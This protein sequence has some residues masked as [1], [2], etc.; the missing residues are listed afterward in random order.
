MK[1][2]F[3]PQ[4]V[5]I[6]EYA[7]FSKAQLQHFVKYSSTYRNT[8]PSYCVKLVSFALGAVM[9]NVNGSYRW[10][11]GTCIHRGFPSLS[12]FFLLLLL[13]PFL[14]L[15]LKKEY[16]S[17]VFIKMSQ[18]YYMKLEERKHSS[19]VL[20]PKKSHCQHLNS[21]LDLSPKNIIK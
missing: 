9:W 13:L 3:V 21:N 16:M 2:K 11:V 14:F 19:K 5:L 4:S 18:N 17:T 20:L 10:K 12:L 1:I 15:Y 7:S 8:V 6:Y